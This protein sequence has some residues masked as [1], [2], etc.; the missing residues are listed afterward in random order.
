MG[1][2][3]LRYRVK[4]LFGKPADGEDGRLL[5]PKQPSIRVWMLGFFTKQKG[6]GGEKVKYKG[7]KSCKHLLEWPALGRECNF[8]LPVAIHSWTGS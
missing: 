1:D 6:R 3:I 4:I 8:F 7:H 5:S 2:K